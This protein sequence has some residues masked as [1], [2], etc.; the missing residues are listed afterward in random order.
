MDALEKENRNLRSLVERLAIYLPVDPIECRGDKCR[1]PWCLSC[2]D[3]ADVYAHMDIV[4]ALQQEA[5]IA[6]KGGAK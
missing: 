5:D 2:C 6:A 4:R 1:E 3:E